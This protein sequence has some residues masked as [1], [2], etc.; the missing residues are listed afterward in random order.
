M[1]CILRNL[2]KLRLPICLYNIKICARKLDTLQKIKPFTDSLFL[3]ERQK[4]TSK[5]PKKFFIMKRWKKKDYF[6][7]KQD[8][9]VNCFFLYLFDKLSSHWILPSEYGFLIFYIWFF[10]LHRKSGMSIIPCYS[11][12]AAAIE[13][14]RIAVHWQ[15]QHQ[16]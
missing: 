13:I 15:L 2:L 5:I 8:Y 11:S 4:A 1:L 14:L 7:K 9:L 3:S 10:L 16:H 6:I 12:L